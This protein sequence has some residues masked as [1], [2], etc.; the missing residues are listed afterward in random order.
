MQIAWTNKNNVFI[1]FKFSFSLNPSTGQKELAIEL[2][3]KG[4]LE[5]ERGIAVECW[6]G[7][8]EVWER[9][10]RLHDKM[11][12]NLSMARDRLHFLGEYCNINMI[13]KYQNKQKGDFAC[14]LLNKKVFTSCNLFNNLVTFP[15]QLLLQYKII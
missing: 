9:A 10:Q 6:G 4:I 2:Y 14:F 8:G 13:V 5:L 1:K 12:T 7:R 3:R 15:L 11:Q